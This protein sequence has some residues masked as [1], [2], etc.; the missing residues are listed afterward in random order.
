MAASQR[1]ITARKQ[2]ALVIGNS[3]YANHPL[4]NPANDAR[5]ISSRL[6]ALNYD[7][8]SILDADHPALDRAIDQFASKLGTD[9]V[10]LYFFSGHGVQVGGENYLL[11][12]DFDGQDEIDVRHDAVPAGRIQERMEQS[13]AQLNILILDACRNNPYRGWNR[14]GMRG[15]APMSGVRGT[16]IAYATGPGRTA[17][18]GAGQN[19][20]FTEHLLNALSLPGLALGELFDVVRERVDAASNGKQT[21][22][23]HSS[24]V[25]R[26]SFVPGGALPIP[27]VNPGPQAGDIKLNPKDGQ[28]YVWI[29]SGTFTMGCSPGDDECFPDETPAHQVTISRGFWLGQTPVTQAA[30]ARVTGRNPSHFKGANLP[31]E[32]INW[33]E[34]RAYCQAIG[35]RLPTEASGSTRHAAEARRRVMENLATSPGITRTVAAGPAKFGKNGRTFSGFTTRWVMCGNGRQTG[36]ETNTTNSE[37]GRIRWG[38]LTVCNE[39]CAVAPGSAAQSSSACRTV[40]RAY[41]AAAPAAGASAASWNNASHVHLLHPDVQ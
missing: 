28:P 22:W 39:R 12:V 38:R 27:V 35:G 15:L 7:V 24:V 23:V 33:A 11:P 17:S 40:A 30:Y 25:G 19:G 32:S 2:V 37:T 34:A 1:E 3:A 16:F 26:Y 21:P 9:D 6:Q 14:S 4:R 36:T 18:D 10:A 8:V 13:G 31:V 20:L 41:R 5:A 29:P